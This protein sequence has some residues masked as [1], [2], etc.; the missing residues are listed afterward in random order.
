MSQIT[1]NVPDISCGHCER[2]ILNALQGQP[3]VES[4]RVSLPTKN[5]YLTYDEQALSID[6]VKDILDEEG[7]PVASVSHDAAPDTQRR[8]FIPLS[9]R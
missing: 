4:V 1:L 5:V 3:G 2:T 8:G 7:Y 6:Q 9:S